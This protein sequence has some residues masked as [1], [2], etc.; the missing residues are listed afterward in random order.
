MDQ[1][2]QV[3]T[4]IA[5]KV[6][7][8]HVTKTPF[9]IYHGYTNS[10][11]KT[12]CQRSRIV[13]TSRLSHVLSVD[14]SAQTAMVEPNVS[15]DRLV[16]E[17]LKYGLVPPVVPEFPAITIGGG[18]AGTAGE[19]SSFKH[20]FLD[21]T[22]NWI[23]VVVPNGEVVIASN[24]ANPDLFHGIKGTFGTLG[25]T[26]LLEVKLVDAKTY[27]SLTYHPVNSV[28]ELLYTLDLGMQDSS[29]DYV[30]AMHYSRNSGVV[31]TGRLTNHAQYGSKVQTFAQPRDEWYYL[32]V[33]NQLALSGSSWT[34]AVP[35][36]DYF[37]R[38]DRGAFWTGKYV[39]TYF[40][41]PFLHT[42]RWLLDSVMHTKILYHGLHENGMAKDNLIQD[43][44]VPRSKAS[45][46]LHWLDETYQIYPLWV[47]PFRQGRHKSMYPR[48]MAPS[49][50]DDHLLAGNGHVLEEKHDLTS[51]AEGDEKSEQSQEMLL[52]V[53]VWGPR[54]PNPKDFVAQNRKL[55]SKVREL[56]G[57]KWLYAHCHYTE[58]EFWQIH[59]KQWYDDLR[60]K[61][62]AQYLPSVYEKTKFDWGAEQRAIEGSW[63]RWLFSFVWWIWPMPGIYGVI[64][65]FM[66]SEYL[67]S[68]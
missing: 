40:G 55:E 44:A 26:T 31:I 12:S 24:T 15:M 5:A 47:C 46:F 67:L 9:K 29:N 48:P 17:T 50:V 13:D 10:T 45:E 49:M 42:L 35:I 61:Y 57:M 65:V 20:G 59:D 62:N 60:T 63:L 8:F 22:I 19:S 34:E 27:V 18:F 25:V 36:V 37:F 39:F 58:E 6:R 4:A 38:Y 2:S 52:S 30:D 51:L 64:C 53:G 1:H 43:V 68:K 11:R 7:H 56:G 14:T 23:E 54:L 16:R 28:R 21:N 66:H 3:V 32:H 41:L 33:Q